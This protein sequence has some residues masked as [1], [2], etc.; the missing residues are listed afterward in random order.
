MSKKRIY[1]SPAL[2]GIDNPTKCPTSCSENTHCGAYMD[3]LQARLTSLGFEVK[4]GGNATGTGA[5]YDRVAESNAFKPYIHYVAHTNAGGGRYSMTMCWDD[6]NSK[7]LANVLHD[8][9]V[10]L[11]DGSWHKVVISKELY[12]IKYVKAVTL[13]DELFFH[14][15]ASDCAWF[16][17]GGMD[18]MVED[19]VKAFCKMCGVKYV[20]PSANT[21]PAPVVKKPVAG[22][23]VKLKK[24]PLYVAAGSKKPVGTATGTYYLWDGKNLFGKYRITCKK[25]WV[26][27]A[28][29]VTGWIDADQVK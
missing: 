17:N 1:L 2:H 10:N 15:N 12:E 4:R 3:K 21:K 13:Y 18:Q 22:Q 23:K 5:M 19:T 7:K 25:A 6:A 27:V 9:R 8:H 16:H 29:Q 20:A 14:D 24:A 26:G 11:P 28:G